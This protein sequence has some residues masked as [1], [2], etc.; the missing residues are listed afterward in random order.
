MEISNIEAEQALLGAILVD[1]KVLDHVI[2][3]HDYH[4][5]DPMHGRIFEACKENVAGGKLASPISLK[6]TFQSDPAMQTVG[7]PA[8]LARLA[9]AAAGATAAKEYAGVV[10]AMWRRRAAHAAISAASERLEVDEGGGVDEIVGDLDIK[11]AEIQD[12]SSTKPKSKSILHAATKAV[13]NMADAAGGKSHGVL[14]GLGDLDKVLGGFKPGR[15]YVIAGRPAMGKTAVGLNIAKRVSKDMGVIVASL[16][17]P[18]DEIATRAISQHLREGGTPIAYQKIENGWVNEGEIKQ[19]AKAAKEIG[20]NSME[21]I[22]PDFRTLSGVLSAIRYAAR[23]FNKDRPLGLIVVDYLQLIIAPGYSQNERIAA[24]SGAMKL[25]AR[26]MNVPVISMSQLSR[27][28]EQR[29]NKRPILSDLRDSGSIEQDA[30]AVIGCYRD[31]YYLSREKPGMGAGVSDQ[32]DWEAAM[33]AV[34]NELELGVIKFRQGAN[35]V[36]RL[37]CE[38]KHNYLSDMSNQEDMGI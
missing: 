21:I 23:K 17:M 37:H 33:S 19:V 22:T 34:R 36:V 15:H 11:L 8:Y 28:C 7:G 20:E 31:E 4:F 32:A 30:D 9:G 24:V 16:E 5:F 13:V 3:L 14:T 12:D 35:T 29:D 27:Q 38:V 1:N 18:E 25:L 6:Y 2:G 10:T 26:S